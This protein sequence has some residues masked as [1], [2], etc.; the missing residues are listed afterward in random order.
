ML[1][2][3]D[4][5]EKICIGQLIS[6][7]YFVNIKLGTSNMIKK[8]IFRTSFFKTGEVSQYKISW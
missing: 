6:N 8:N 1:A 3:S 2:L 4:E 5:D 7:A